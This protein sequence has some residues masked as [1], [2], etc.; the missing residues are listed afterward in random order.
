MKSF[1]IRLEKNGTINVPQAIQDKLN[2]CEGDLL[3]LD[4]H[5]GSQD[6]GKRWKKKQ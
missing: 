1:A 3:N 5:K 4:N 2:I 6:K